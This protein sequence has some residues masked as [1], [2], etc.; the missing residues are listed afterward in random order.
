MFLFSRPYFGYRGIKGCLF[1]ENPRESRNNYIQR[2]NADAGR[3]LAIP[4]MSSEFPKCFFN[5]FVRSFLQHCPEV[6]PSFPG[7]IFQLT[8]DVVLLLQMFIP[9][10]SWKVY[11]IP[12]YLASFFELNLPDTYLPEF[13]FESPG[14]ICLL[15][16]FWNI[17][18]AT[19]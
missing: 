3:V 4:E 11:P 2:S 14:S 15:D 7:N 10:L 18:P 17:L 19:P 5:Y 16:F 6:S 9:G 1:P 8:L 12:A 13:F